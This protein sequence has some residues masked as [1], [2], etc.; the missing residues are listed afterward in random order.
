MDE[1]IDSMSGMTASVLDYKNSPGAIGFSFK[2]YLDTMIQSDQIKILAIDGVAPGAETVGSGEYPFTVEFQA[3]TAT[4]LE[5][6]VNSGDSADRAAN[7][8]R[9]LEWIGSAQG[10]EL[11]RKTGYVPLRG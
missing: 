3:V 5:T 11:V 1:R 2:Y 7:T 4:S 6:T 8:R 10:Q 9:L